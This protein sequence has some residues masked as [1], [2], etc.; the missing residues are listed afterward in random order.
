MNNNHFEPWFNR[1]AFQELQNARFAFEE[2][3]FNLVSLL[4][5]GLE[6]INENVV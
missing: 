3:R 4:Y 6:S 2:A 5:V 1:D